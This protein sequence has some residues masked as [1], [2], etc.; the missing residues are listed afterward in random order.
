MK[1]IISVA[2]IAAALAL[3]MSCASTSVKGS[4]YKGKAPTVAKSQVEIIDYQGA[5][6]GS[7]IPQ[8]V[9]LVSQGQYSNTVLS[10][11]MPDLKDKK[12]FVTIAQG[13]NLEFVK[14]W[15][16]LVDVEVQVGDT[17]QRVVGKAVSASEAATAKET[18]KESDPTEVERKLN[19]YKE[20]VS[21]VEVNG[22]EKV[23]SYWI[24][25]K[26]TS[27]KKD[28]KDVFEYYAV[29]AMDQKKFDTQLDAAMKNVKDNTSEGAALKKALSAKLTGIVVSSNSADVENDADD[30]NIVEAK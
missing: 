28:V 11:S 8:W 1:K 24:E 30:Q 19:M 20:A 22:L 26:V 5:S 15:T 3:V 13:D 7:E 10:Q 16:D 9:V 6:F 17:M 25:K 12:V 4:G 14:Q 29:W 23:A 21:T 2:F 18:G 27:N